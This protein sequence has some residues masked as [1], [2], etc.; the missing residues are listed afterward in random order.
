MMTSQALGQIMVAVARDTLITSVR[1]AG[2]V[3]VRSGAG[4]SS[5]CGTGGNSACYTRAVV[6][7]SSAVDA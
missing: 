4:G 2:G 5:C 7:G 1:S 6:R 3:A